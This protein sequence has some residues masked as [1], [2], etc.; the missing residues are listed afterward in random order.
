V[1]FA[2]SSPVAPASGRLAGSRPG[3]RVGGAEALAEDATEVEH[4]AQGEPRVGQSQS[5]EVAVRGNAITMVERRRPWRRD[6]G[7]EW[8]SQ[9]IAQLRYDS[10]KRRWS[11]YWRDSNDRWHLYSEIKPSRD[12]APLLAEVDAD[13]A[14]IFWG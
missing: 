12:L 3:E 9:K 1:S 4:E 10:A 14:G 13:P 5:L 7:P 8:S 11:L 2:G 6:F